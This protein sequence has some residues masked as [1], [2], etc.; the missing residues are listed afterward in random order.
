MRRPITALS[1]FLALSAARSLPAQR[2][3][4]LGLGGGV[5]IPQ[6][7]LSS[8]ANTGWNAL[9]ALILGTPMQPLGLR[10]DVAYNQFPFS[11]AS[12]SALGAGNHRIG[13][14]TAS[15]TY[16]LPTP[17]TPVSPDL[18]AGLGAYRMDCSVSSACE[19]TTHFGWNAGLGMKF[20]TLGFRSFVEARYQRTSANGS[21]VNYFPVTLGLLF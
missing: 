15:A 11:A 14:L 8:V 13:S 7:D 19:A 21:T 1:V 9:G 17:G 10:A 18:I 4:T 6:A 12:S 16:R 20:Y 5:T 3:I 2:L